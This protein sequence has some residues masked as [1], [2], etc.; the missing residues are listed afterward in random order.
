[1]KIISCCKDCQRR[2]VGCHSSCEEYIKEKAAAEEN[3]KKKV[4]AKEF[5]AYCSCKGKRRV[6]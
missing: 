5:D 4:L 2:K 1:M 3:R 6:I